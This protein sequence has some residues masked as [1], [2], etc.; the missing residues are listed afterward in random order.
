MSDTKHEAIENLKKKYKEILRSE[1]GTY[2]YFF[3]RNSLN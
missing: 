2:N 3:N 1:K